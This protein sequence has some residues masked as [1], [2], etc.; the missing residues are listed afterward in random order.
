MAVFDN[1]MV[2]FGNLMRHLYSPSIVEILLLVCGKERS[3]SEEQDFRELKFRLLDGIIEALAIDSLPLSLEERVESTSQFLQ[4]MVEKAVYGERFQPLIE[5]LLCEDKVRC[6]YDVF[7]L[8]SQDD[9][10][11]AAAINLL[12]S[13]FQYYKPKTINTRFGGNAEESVIL[14]RPSEELRESFR[15][16]VSFIAKKVMEYEAKPTKTYILKTELSLSELLSSYCRL[17][18]E[19]ARE[20][21]TKEVCQWAF[22]LF[23]LHPHNNILH[24]WLTTVLETYVE[25]TQID[26]LLSDRDLGF[27]QFIASHYRID[28]HSEKINHSFQQHLI[29]ILDRFFNQPLGD[30]NIDSLIGRQLDIESWESI[31]RHYFQTKKLQSEELCKQLAPETDDLIFDEEEVV[32]RFDPKLQNG[33]SFSG[34]FYPNNK[35]ELQ[36][37]FLPEDSGIVMEH[38]IGMAESILCCLEEEVIVDTIPSPK[39]NV[40][41]P[42]KSP[43]SSELTAMK[44]EEVTQKAD[45]SANRTVEEEIQTDPLKT[46]ETEEV[47]WYP[48]EQ[49]PSS[50]EIMVFLKNKLARM[51]GQIWNRFWH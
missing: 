12:Q 39:I 5:Y 14:P 44:F 27:L 6:V 13:F 45:W 37:S 8:H 38:A 49:P 17:W 24:N 51:I 4:E 26:Y 35:P 36:L 20:T 50:L 32:V 21:I 29:I 1:K 22:K 46:E 31:K 10:I 3:D 47:L 34:L 48:Q 18:P 33:A 15:Y 7:N 25:S 40:I 19:L 2:V 41:H 43:S 16:A 28:E 42:L 30:Y 23:K 9:G 11:A